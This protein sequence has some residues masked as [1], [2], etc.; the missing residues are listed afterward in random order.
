MMLAGLVS[1]GCSLAGCRGAAPIE[2]SPLE[3]T[4]CPEQGYQFYVTQGG[5]D[6]RRIEWELVG[7]EISP[8]G[9]YL[10]PGEIGLYSVTAVQQGSGQR[11][12][13]M[14]EVVECVNG[15]PALPLPPTEIPP[16][17]REPTGVPVPTETSA[18]V[19]ASDQ[20]A[21]TTTARPRPTAMLAPTKTPV[22]P[23]ANEGVRDPVGD[24]AWLD[25]LAPADTNLPGADIVL[26]SLDE[27]GRPLP[28]PA[29]WPEIEGPGMAYDLALG[30]RLE[31][32]IPEDP[33]SDRYW[34]FALDVDGDR[35]TGRPL[36]DGAINPDLGVEVTIGVKWSPALGPQPTA[37]V[38]VWNAETFTSDRL[39]DGVDAIFSDDRNRVYVRIRRERLEQLV[40]GRS[41]TE[42]DWDRM[43][44]RAGTLALTE[45]GMV[46]DFCPD[47]P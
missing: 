4:L 19:S 15:K 43:V 39:T 33:A 8:G 38:Y 34:L 46:A 3:L 47:L 32:P 17:T 13:A 23:G 37:Y 45:S 40:S 28:A 25:T 14:V 18:A 29:G 9:F 7:G 1:A 5:E 21:A 26:A 16:P 44:G 2:I 20:P 35:A 30:M 31:P 24:L 36:G 6:A 11:V 10:A 22:P 12:V 42:V 41:G 27:A